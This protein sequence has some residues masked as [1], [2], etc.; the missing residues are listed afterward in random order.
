MQKGQ[1][2]QEYVVLL[3]FAVLLATPHAQ[4]RQY[5]QHYKRLLVHVPASNIRW[6]KRMGTPTSFSWAPTLGTG[7]HLLPLPEELPAG[8]G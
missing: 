6:V 1:Q 2:V 7:C 3:I 8:G 5:K 4:D